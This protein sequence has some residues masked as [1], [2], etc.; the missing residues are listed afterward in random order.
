MELKE[1]P[2]RSTRMGLERLSKHAEVTAHEM[3]RR[4]KSSNVFL[5]PVASNCLGVT[6]AYEKLPKSRSFAEERSTA[7]GS[8]PENILGFGC[9][10]NYLGE[11]KEGE[12]KKK[13]K[14]SSWLPDPNNRWPI[15]GF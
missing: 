8:S 5:G 11:P 4:S 15:Q 14:R 9:D 6:N 13:K 10:D 3:V 12:E 7:A 2:A 1:K